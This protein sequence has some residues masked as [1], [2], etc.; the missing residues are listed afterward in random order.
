MTTIRKLGPEDRKALEAFL[1]RY[2]ASSMFLRSNLHLS[3]LEEGQGRYHGLYVGAFAG[4]A[5]TD[6]AAHY[7]NN[8]IILQAP[9][10]PVEVATAVAQMSGQ[11]VN[12]VIGPWAQVK[13]AEPELDL[14]RSRLGKVVPEHL[15]ELK[16][17]KIRLPQVL[18][19]GDVQHRLAQE[20]D[21]DQLVAWRHVY[22]RITM[23]FPEHAIIDDQN[24]DMLSGM[25][26]D[27]RLWVLIRQGRLVAMSGFNATLPDTV[28]VGGVYTDENYRGRG[29]AR[30][31][32]AATLRDAR[33]AGVTQALLFTEMDNVPAQRA[34]ESLGFER[35]GDYGMVVLDPS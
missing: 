32:V 14:D 21:L 10:L 31:L 16:L 9:N 23:G 27:D 28:Q 35:V 7:W 19:S 15:Y 17:G 1:D 30:A 24:R 25:I 18:L 3:G 8:N 4:D 2:R 33:D 5:L 20:E 34:Y 22:D 29:Y 11:V 6:V 13:A 12:G 26:E